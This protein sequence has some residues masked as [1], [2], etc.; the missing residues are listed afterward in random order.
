MDNHVVT[1]EE[2]AHAAEA[3]VDRLIE[4]NEKE[5]AE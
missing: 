3:F 4:E 5:E 2:V 1:P